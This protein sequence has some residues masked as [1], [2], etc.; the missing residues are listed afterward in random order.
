[1]KIPLKPDARVKHRSYRLNT[2]SEEHA[3]IELDWMLDGGII[4][5]I[6]KL[7]WIILMV[8]Q[9]KNP[10]KIRICVDLRKLNDAIL[11]GPFITPFINEVLEG[12]GGKEI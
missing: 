4:E 12:I 7:E 10:G 3:K 2:R 11:H 1:M 8:V 9:D 5:P 6:N